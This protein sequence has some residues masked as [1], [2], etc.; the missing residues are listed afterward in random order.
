MQG[1]LSA[2]RNVRLSVK[3]VNC[4]KNEEKRVP[5]FLYPIKGRISSSLTGIM[6]G[7]QQQVPEILGSK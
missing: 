4:G 7:G 5:K 2:E 3:R 6:V 1:G